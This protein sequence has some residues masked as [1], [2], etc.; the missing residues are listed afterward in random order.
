V[1]PAYLAQIERR[2]HPTP[3]S[4]SGFLRQKLWAYTASWKKHRNTCTAHPKS[5]ACCLRPRLLACAEIRWRILPRC[6]IDLETFNIQSIGGSLTTRLYYKPAATDAFYLSSMQT[7]YRLLI[8]RRANH[9]YPFWSGFAA[10]TVGHQQV[11]DIGACSRDHTSARWWHW[12]F[13]P[14]A[15]LKGIGMRANSVNSWAFRFL[16]NC[17]RREKLLW[18]NWAS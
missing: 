14:A 4:P 6:S 17:W 7:S 1:K 10:K 16:L 5:R 15:G 18:S 13:W 3:H 9:A 12:A 2:A 8:L 11:E